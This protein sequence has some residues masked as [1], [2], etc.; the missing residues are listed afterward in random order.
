MAALKS[1]IRENQYVKYIYEKCTLAHIDARKS[2]LKAK[3]KM[4]TGIT[5]FLFVFKEINEYMT[6][7]VDPKNGVL[8]FPD[9]TV[10]KLGKDMPS[11][12]KLTNKNIDKIIEAL[13]QWNSMKTYAAEDFEL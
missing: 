8:Q 13:S 7:F 10:K 3:N 2:P 9:T 4:N 6:M 11:S 5:I 12:I 1:L